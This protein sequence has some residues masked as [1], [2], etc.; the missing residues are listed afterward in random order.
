MTSGEHAK[1]EMKEIH[2]YVVIDLE[3]TTSDDGSLPRD[4]METIEIGAVLV[5]AT[6]YEVEGEFQCMVRPVRHTVLTPFCCS[7]TGISQE[8]V[9]GG[10]GFAHAMQLLFGA[11]PLSEPG[12][13]WSS[14]G[15]FDDTQLRR[16]CAFHG[17]PYEMPRHMNL[18][19]RFVSAQGKRSRMG[20]AATLELC[21]LSLEGAH[22]RAL[23][24]ARNIARL[25]PWCIGERK[26][27]S[28]T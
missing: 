14:W 17:I 13:V 6:T 18:K 19:Q 1:R 4:E 28:H 22:H 25:L 12:V 3:A 2:R 9:D 8:M 23:D 10:P 11:M 24:D 26:L 7:L 21:G 5:N 27:D 20:M 16:D 15:Q